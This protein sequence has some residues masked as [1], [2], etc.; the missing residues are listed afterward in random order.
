MPGPDHIDLPLPV[1]VLD[2]LFAPDGIHDMDM[3]FVPDQSIYVVFCAKLRSLSG[4]VADHS[5][6]EICGQ[7]GIKY[8]PVFIGNNVYV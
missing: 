6:S 2:L 3:G 4:L 5:V 1:P 8:R 7:P